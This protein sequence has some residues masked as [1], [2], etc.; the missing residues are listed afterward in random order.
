MEKKDEL[1]EIFARKI[2]GELNLHLFVAT[3]WSSMLPKVSSF[4]KGWDALRKYHTEKDLG[5]RF[6]LN[7]KNAL[8]K[9]QSILSSVQKMILAISKESA[10]LM[11]ADIA[12]T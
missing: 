2:S 3:L 8:S 5:F 11:T 1:Q 4:L 12:V 10:N 6:T 7:E 9:L